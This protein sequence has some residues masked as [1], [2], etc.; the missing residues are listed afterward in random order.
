M[1]RLLLSLALALAL[2]AVAQHYRTVMPDG[3][4]WKGVAVSF[5]GLEGDY[6][7]TEFSVAVAGDTVVADRTVRKLA[8][9][10]KLPGD[11]SQHTNIVLAFEDNG[12]VYLYDN[13]RYGYVFVGEPGNVVW[14]SWA[15]FKI[16]DM[17]YVVGDND[18]GCGCDTRVTAADTVTVRGVSRRRLTVD[19]RSYD[20][21][22]T[23][24]YWVDGIGA[25]VLYDAELAYD[26]PT[27]YSAFNYMYVTHCYDN[28]QLVFSAADY[29]APATSICG[30]RAD[31]AVRHTAIYDLSGRPVA[32][33]AAGGVYIRDGRKMVWPVGE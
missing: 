17:G 14:E 19:K 24:T 27:N 13:D 1:R 7:E 4:V 2:P 21:R 8:Y 6:V 3:R 10:Y 25:S 23:R 12:Q 26:L 18:N 28:G 29:A 33:P 31:E 15:D 11:D 30:A 32:S 20:G 5:V 9:T 22:F 16:F